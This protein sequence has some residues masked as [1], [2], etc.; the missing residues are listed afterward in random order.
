MQTLH[1]DLRNRERE[2]ISLLRKFVECESP[3]HDKS[4]VDRFGT[5]VANEWRRRGATVRLL[6]QRERGDHVRAEVWFD[7]GRPKRQIL[8]LGHLD[9]VYPIGTLAEMP[10]RVQGGRAWGPGIFDMKTGI[11][12]AL[13]AVDALRQVQSDWSKRLVFFWNSDEEIGSETSRRTIEREAQRS[14]TVLV[15]EP[16]YGAQGKLKTARKG[17]GTVELVVRGRSSHAGLDPAQGV[18]AVHELALQ[19]VRLMKMS[20]RRRGITVQA[21]VAAGGTVSNVVPSHARA[22]VDIR[23]AHLADAP[24]LDR[25]LRGLRPILPGA[26]LEVT[27]GMNRPPLERT[28]AVGELF[29][30]AHVLLQELN[31]PLGEVSVGGGSDGN[32]T[33]ALGV[34]TLD[35]LG[36]IGGGAHS[37]SEHVLIRALSSRAALLAGL[38]ASL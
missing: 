26:Q 27:G 12:L 31:L 29:R 14:D 10:F 20:D 24:I 25:K 7:R 5:M 3:S 36:A 19:I 35:G 8:V 16:S 30:R 15:M 22:Q 4:A 17:V 18:N 1:R 34:P 23:Y 28:A 32:F 13:F 9:T 21:T 38:L 37:P 33:A 2:M 11:A 6:R